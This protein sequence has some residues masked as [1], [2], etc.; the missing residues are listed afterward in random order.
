MINSGD[1]SFDPIATASADDIFNYAEENGL[2]ISERNAA[3][4]GPPEKI[5]QLL[6]ITINGLAQHDNHDD[7]TAGVIDLIG[8]LEVAVIYG[9]HVTRL[10]AAKRMYQAEAAATFINKAL[11]DSAKSTKEKD[12]YNELSR[13]AV[14]QPSFTQFPVEYWKNKA[15][16]QGKILDNLLHEGTAGV[17]IPNESIS[18]Q[19]HSFQ[20]LLDVAALRYE[21]MIQRGCDYC[22]YEQQQINRH[23]G[24]E[25]KIRLSTT[26]FAR[27]INEDLFATVERL[28][29]PSVK[30]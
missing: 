17:N 28:K 19:N 22:N 27:L 7:D 6:D 15:L 4:G 12:S 8:D 26:D 13:A 21:A 18:V 5:M 11:R 3:C 20:Y 14:D 29:S 25:S 10:E 1:P 2:F 16:N 9:I 30:K 24:L 23:L